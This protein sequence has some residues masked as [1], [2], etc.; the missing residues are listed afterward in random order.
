MTQLYGSW[1]ECFGELFN[2]KVEIMR[3]MPNNV[4]EIDV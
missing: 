2:W 1:E 3:K 4:I